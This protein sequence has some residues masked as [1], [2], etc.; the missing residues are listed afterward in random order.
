VEQFK[1]ESKASHKKNVQLTISYFLE[2][3]VTVEKKT[4]LWLPGRYIGG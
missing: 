3:N 1:K 2:D 4:L